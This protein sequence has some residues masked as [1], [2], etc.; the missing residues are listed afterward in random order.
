MKIVCSRQ[1]LVEAVSNVQ[2]AVS[3]KSSVPALEGI[4]LRTS[5]GEVTLCGYDLELG[6]TTSIESSVEESGSVVL[7]AR[8]F[9]D[10]VRRLPGESVSL[11]IDEKNITTIKSGASEFSIVGIPAD[12]YPDMPAISGDDSV[13][14]PQHLLKGM[15]RQ[16]IFA[17]AESDAKETLRRYECGGHQPI[18]EG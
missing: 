7:S 8:L 2:R 15:I 13:T 14:L 9:A 12:E 4:L 17:V 3:T 10:I 11:T 5:G 1:Q 16:T 6:M 18:H